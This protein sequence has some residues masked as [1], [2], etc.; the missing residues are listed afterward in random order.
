M[1]NDDL[2]EIHHFGVVGRRKW[3]LTGSHRRSGPR[4]GEFRVYP[5]EGGN[6]SATP[7]II[8]HLVYTG[9]WWMN[10]CFWVC[11]G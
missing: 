8:H 3:A 11:I 10:Y 5:L 2:E 9:G 4:D 7:T 1:S 6:I